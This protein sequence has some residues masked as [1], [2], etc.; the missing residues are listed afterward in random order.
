MFQPL[1][2]T[3]STTFTS[4]VEVGGDGGGW[5]GV[6]GGGS[7]RVGGKGVQKRGEV[8]SKSPQN[9]SLATQ[10]LYGESALHD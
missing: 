5:G 8:L 1:S 3:H 2:P 10:A 6:G 9:S 7:G 4:G